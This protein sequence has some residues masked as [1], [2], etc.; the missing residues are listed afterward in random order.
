MIR[1]KYFKKYRLFSIKIIEVAMTKVTKILAGILLIF[2]LFACSD[3]STNVTAEKMSLNQ[4]AVTPGYTWFNYELVAYQPNIAVVDEVKNQFNSSEHSFLVFAKP[5][6]SCPGKHKQTPEFFKTLNLASIPVEKCEIYSMSSI[7][8][9]HPFKDQITIKE[10]PTIL[11]LKNGVPVYSISD[12][13]NAMNEINPSTALN[14]EQA[15]LE[16]LKK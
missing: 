15:L 4:L 2:S 5:S 11:I 7:S 13:V 9:N 1:N 10:L 6:C 16:G 12:T 14:V 3:N 8:T